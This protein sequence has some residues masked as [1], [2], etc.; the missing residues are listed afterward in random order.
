[1]HVR[2][3]IAFPDIPGCVGPL[4]L[5]FRDARF[6]V[7]DDVLGLGMG[8]DLYVGSLTRYH[9]GDWELVAQT[10]ARELGLPLKVV[11]QHDPARAKSPAV[12]STTRNTAMQESSN[13]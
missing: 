7:H 8:L 2:S 3:H 5:L 9:V 11:R 13:E 1:M 12:K 10:A 4:Q 6:F